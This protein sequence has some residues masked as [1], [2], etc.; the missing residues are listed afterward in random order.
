MSLSIPLDILGEVSEHLDHSYDILNLCLTVYH[1]LILI[2]WSVLDEALQA[3]AV[4]ELLTPLRYRYL[5]L[6]TSQ[7]CLT[8]LRHLVSH[9]NLARHVRTLLL[10]PNYPKPVHVY[11]PED[12]QQREAEILRIVELLAPNLHSLEKFIWDGLE[13]PDDHVWQT[14]HECCP[15]LRYIGSDVG[16]RPID[17][18]SKMFAFEGLLGFTLKSNDHRRDY[19]Q[20]TE[21]PP[22][23]WIMLLDRCPHLQ[24]LTLGLTG[25][26]DEQIRAIGAARRSFNVSPL[27]DATF[28]DL[29]TLVLQHGSANGSA[30]D[31]IRSFFARHQQIERLDVNGS[32]YSDNI[33]V[34]LTSL[35][36]AYPVLL[37]LSST[38]G[39]WTSSSLRELNFSGRPLQFSATILHILSRLDCLTSL[40]LWVD[41]RTWMVER[42]LKSKTAS[43]AALENILSCRPLLVEI[44][45]MFAIGP[46]PPCY[47][48]D[49]A[50]AINMSQNLKRLELWKRSKKDDTA[51][52]QAAREFSRACPSLERITLRSTT[53]PSYWENEVIL[54][55]AVYHVSAADLKGRRIFYGRSRG[56]DKSMNYIVSKRS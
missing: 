18:E 41:L 40:A 32:D 23:L 4:N 55:H 49:L 33:P 15:R 30:R 8:Q 44:K 12:L 7:R 52:F 6:K 14:L 54:Q 21:L 29:H 20:Y 17:P 51:S 25:Y 35:S 47:W 5:D 3:R 48:S 19:P 11:Q 46:N 2:P 34:H 26:G 28:P 37:S 27:M 36:I 39:L 42:K 13:I 45:Y 22:A 50:P 38:L 43:S 10:C 9:P 56:Q 53:L 1:L 31:K 24:E 16:S